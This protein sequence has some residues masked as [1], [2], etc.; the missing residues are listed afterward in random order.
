MEFKERS[1]KEIL[2][3]VFYSSENIV[4]FG[5]KLFAMPLAFL[6][7]WIGIGKIKSLIINLSLTP[8]W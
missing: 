1:S 2:G 8:K 7:L 3:I 5:E 4:G 6:L